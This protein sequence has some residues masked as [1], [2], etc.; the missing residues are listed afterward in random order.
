[1]PTARGRRGEGGHPQVGA[2]Q[3]PPGQVFERFLAFVQVRKGNALGR[4]ALEELAQ[5]L[6]AV[7]NLE[8]EQAIR[9]HRGLHLFVVPLEDV[10]AV[11]TIARRAEHF[12]EQQIDE[13]NEAV[14][15]GMKRKTRN[16]SVVSC[17]VRKLSNQRWGS[18][19]V[20]TALA[21]GNSRINSR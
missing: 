10:N 8:N 19:T 17:N 12:V 1:M 7:L 16:W 14:R 20:S 5:G 18:R 2:E 3:A 13:A 21:S 15:R 4:F 9:R 6:P 11:L